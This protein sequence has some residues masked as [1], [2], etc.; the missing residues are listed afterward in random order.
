MALSKTSKGHHTYVGIGGLIAVMFICVDNPL[1]ASSFFGEVECASLFYQSALV[2]TIASSLVLAV[3]GVLSVRAPKG[4]LALGVFFAIF[5]VLGGYLASLLSLPGLTFAIFGTI[6]GAGCSA[7]IVRWGCLYATLS[8]KDSMGLMSLAGIGGAILKLVAL[9]LS[10]A[11]AEGSLFV[12]VVALLVSAHLPRSSFPIGM[13]PVAEG[14]DLL[15]RTQAIVFQNWKM[16]AGLLLCIF[17]S[18]ATW[19]A[20][21]GGL[22]I[23][24]NPGLESAWGNALGLLAA[25]VALYAIVRMAP[26]GTFRVLY[27]AAPLLC[28]S[29]MLLIWFFGGS[30]GI[31]RQY[32]ERLEPRSVDQ[33][34]LR[35]NVG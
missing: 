12:M 8:E 14:D 16:I 22:G 10:T 29:G 20:L 3:R 33:G 32:V 21:L 34:P 13:R 27:Q 11:F 4:R 7:A 9:A 19:S 6:F 1:A 23:S 5:G 24:N 25:P 26:W 35:G 18:A 30:G 31:A 2:G 17:I 15:D 28:V